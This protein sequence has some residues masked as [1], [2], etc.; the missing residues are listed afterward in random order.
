MV[1]N[2]DPETSDVDVLRDQGNEHFKAKRYTEAE[3]CYKAAL[4]GTQSDSK[5]YSNLSACCLSLSRPDEALSH[6][7]HCIELDP[8]WS[9]GYFR[10]ANAQKS[11]KQDELALISAVKCAFY[12]PSYRNELIRPSASSPFHFAN[13]KCTSFTVINNQADMANWQRTAKFEAS[14]H[15]LVINN[16]QVE[17]ERPL[18]AACLVLVGI[19]SGSVEQQASIKASRFFDMGLLLFKSSCILSD[20]RFATHGVHS[21]SATNASRLFVHECELTN[22]GPASMACICVVDNT[23]LTMW[24][25]RIV[26]SN[27]AGVLASE[28]STLSM[29]ECEVRNAGIKMGA[30]IE[31]RYGSVANINACTVDKCKQG[32][33]VWLQPGNVTIADSLVSNSRT[34]G[35]L[36]VNDS[37]QTFAGGPQPAFVKPV[38]QICRIVGNTIC[39]NGAFGVTTD[40]HSNVVMSRNEIAFNGC[41]GVIVKGNTSNTLTHNYIHSNK[42]DGIEIGINYAASVLVRH[43]VIKNNRREQ[44]GNLYENKIFQ[45]MYASSLKSYKVRSFKLSYVFMRFVY[46]YLSSYT[47][48]EKKENH[49]IQGF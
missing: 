23:S 39:S 11:L 33:L 8:T 18:H 25:T 10:L 15:V 6:A 43:N 41:S 42:N 36:I 38:R 29:N 28:N 26:D 34:E 1:L 16:C 19:R 5:L 13:F 20:L 44:I 40:E 9:K 24:R 7:R 48:S 32:I 45:R 27:E 21:I 3:S 4:R 35:I 14:C 30:G 31:I 22:C 49:Q 12:E 17:F 37:S 2:T 46:F 47:I